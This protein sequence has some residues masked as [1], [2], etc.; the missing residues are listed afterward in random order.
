MTSGS[1]FLFQKMSRTHSL[2]A[3]FHLR[4]F[5]SYVF[6]VTRVATYTLKVNTC[7][8][9]RIC[10]NYV[11]LHSCARPVTNRIRIFY[12]SLTQYVCAT[13]TSRSRIFFFFFCLL[14]VLQPSTAFASFLFYLCALTLCVRYGH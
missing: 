5:K 8:N 9:F 3:Y 6:V 7:V 4:A 14:C 12:L 10:H 13:A 11:F 2:Y 1:L